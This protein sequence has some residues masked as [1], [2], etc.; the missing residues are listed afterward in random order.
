MQNIQVEMSFEIFEEQEVL[1]GSNLMS[2]RMT[3]R[4]QDWK[5]GSNQIMQNHRQ[6]VWILIATDYVESQAKSLDLIATV[7]ILIAKAIGGFKQG[8]YEGI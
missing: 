6:K 8:N 1:C 7:W 5:G 3:D 2:R 4:S